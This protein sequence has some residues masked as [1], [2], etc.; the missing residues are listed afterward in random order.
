ME[1]N[2]TVQAMSQRAPRSVLCLVFL[3]SVSVC[4][5]VCEIERERDNWV[6]S[7]D[8]PLTNVTHLSRWSDLALSRD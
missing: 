5:F 3:V 2:L 6:V 8:C 1:R 7:S 4:L